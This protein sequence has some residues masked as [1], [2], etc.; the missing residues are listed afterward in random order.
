M[1]ASVPAAARSI[2]ISYRREETAYPAGWLFDLLV[3]QF[4]K[5]RVF[6]DVDS[7][8]LG[9]DFV[10]KINETIERCD[11]LLALIGKRW[12]TLTSDD[13]RRRLDNP[14]DFVRLEIETGLS[15]NI[16]VIPVLIDGARMPDVTELPPSMSKLAYR[17][18]LELGPSR[19]AADARRL[20]R[21]LTASLD[22]IQGRRESASATSNW[23]QRLA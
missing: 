5:G 21:A 19:F 18:A 12:L 22:E 23:P 14:D 11:V 7:I 20:L 1:M 3:E 4:G 6:K 2:F 15:R 16:R 17:Q 8:L 13:G 10:E 9:D